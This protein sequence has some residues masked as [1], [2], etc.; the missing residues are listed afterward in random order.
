MLATLLLVTAHVLQSAVS[1]DAR[2][3]GRTFQTGEESVWI[4]EISGKRIGHHTSR[5]LGRDDE[6]GVGA[7]HFRGAIALDVAQLGAVE[8]RSTADL[9]TD[10][11]G[12]PIRFVQQALVGDN[13]SRVD[14]QAAGKK[15]RAH[16]VQGPTERDVDLDVDPEAYLLANNFVSHLEIAARLQPAAD[17]SK[18][19]KLKLFSGNS[20][21]GLN[22]TLTST[23]VTRVSGDSPEHTAER[24]EDS[25][26]ETL[27]FLD[28]RLDEVEVK[29]QKLVI[30]RADERF[31]PIVIAPPTIAKSAAEFAAR[32]VR[33]EH[34][35]AV[36]AGT[37]T[38]KKDSTGRLPAVFFISGSGPQDRNG[39]SSGIDLGTHEILDRLTSEGFLV[40]RVDDRGAG[41]S[42]AL[43]PDASYDDLVADAR[44]CVG[45]LAQESDVDSARIALIG[46]SEGAETASILAAE[47]PRISAIV[48]MAPAGR[49]ILEI[50]A[51][52]NRLVLEKQKL[53]PDEIEKQ[54]KAVRGFFA[55]LAGDEPIDPRTLS[56]PEER[57][58]L[59]SRAWYRSH[60]RQYPLANLL[61]VKCPVLIL[62]GAKD[63]QVSP[64]KDAGALEAALKNAHHSD[65]ELR[66]F[67]DLD[68]L[69]KKASGATSELSDYW[70]S[71]PVDA[72]FLDALAQWMKQHLKLEGR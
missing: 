18:P 34:A 20:L 60:V 14:L 50:I 58:A 59:A 4:F 67:P 37:I 5:Y 29:G 45:Y 48:L 31:P 56:S 70:K 17:A 10:D 11:L 57:T 39:M 46:H 49:S 7:H 53:A 38:K 52:Q 27:R 2:T 16:I 40:L 13:Y 66:V 15:S 68:H 55:R 32:D 26:G 43:P 21:Q 28:G 1:T 64:E 12:H 65:H 44:A 25:L 19:A 33:I 35:G 51:D 8:L 72:A 22:Y 36:I 30:R 42:S 6:A 54:L 3:V 62:Q 69:F 71:R 24:F 63:F 47:E 23:A 9:W 61:K 41:A